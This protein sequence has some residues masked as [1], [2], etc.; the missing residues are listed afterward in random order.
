MQEYPSFRISRVLGV[1]DLFLLKFIFFLYYI[2]SHTM[3]S[4]YIFIL[5]MC[6]QIIITNIS[7]K[8]E[9]HSVMVKGSH[10]CAAPWSYVVT[11]TIPKSRS[12]L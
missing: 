1:I 6:I 2:T 12:L 11:Y 3:L 10:N 9:T 5:K 8:T 7:S 4:T